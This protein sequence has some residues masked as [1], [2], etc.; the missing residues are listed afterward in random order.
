MRCDPN[1]RE[2]ETGGSPRL[3]VQ[4]TRETIF[5]KA[6]WSVPEERHPKVTS[7]LHMH[8]HTQAP[9]PSLFNILFPEMQKFHNDW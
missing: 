4:A 7:D 5:Q 6:K 8:S 3:D 1:T 9:S 2:A